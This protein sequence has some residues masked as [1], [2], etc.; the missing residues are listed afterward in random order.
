MKAVLAVAA[1]TLLPATAFAQAAAA[2]LPNSFDDA[3]PARVAAP[4]PQAPDVIRAETALRALIASIQANEVDYAVFSDDLAPRIRQQQSR[5]APVIQGFGAL[6]TVAYIGDESGA[7]L[8][9]VGFANARTQWLIGFDPDDRIAA[10]LFRPAPA[11]EP[12][13]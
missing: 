2:T 8:F 1:L 13:A 5:I 9:A 10:L 3:A 12:A 4:T 7:A 6:Q 11:A